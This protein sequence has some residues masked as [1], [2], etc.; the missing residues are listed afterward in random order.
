MTVIEE[1]EKRI[2]H[3]KM[4]EEFFKS[5]LELLKS[6]EDIF[7]NEVAYF[8]YENEVKPCIIVGVDL[9]N[10]KQI[11]NG[12]EPSQVQVRIQTKSGHFVAPLKDV[13]PYNDKAR[14]LYGK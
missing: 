6:K 8:K 3:N 9:P 2:K 7:K 4:C 5:T 10:F 13:F 11:V 12:A 1:V 14:I